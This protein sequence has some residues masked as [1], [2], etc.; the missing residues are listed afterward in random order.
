MGKVKGS[1]RGQIE[2]LGYQ[3]DDVVVDLVRRAQAFIFAAREEFGIAGVEAQAAGTPVIAF[4]AGGS[5][6]TIKGI[7][8]G[9]R[10]QRPPGFFSGNKSL[11]HSLRLSSG[12]SIAGARSSP[13][14]AGTTRLALTGRVFMRNFAGS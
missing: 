9:D 3:P 13:R 1:A 8:P 10:P 5:L 6:E 7:F 4:E 11:P 2:V 14:P 12:S